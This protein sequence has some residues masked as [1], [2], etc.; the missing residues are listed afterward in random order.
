MK[1]LPNTHCKIW[2][3]KPL[4]LTFAYILYFYDFLCGRHV[5]LVAKKPSLHSHTT[6]CKV[7]TRYLLGLLNNKPVV[8]RL[9]RH[10]VCVK[11][12]ITINVIIAN[13]FVVILLEI[14]G[15]KLI[16]HFFLSLS[17]SFCCM[18]LIKL[19]FKLVMKVVIVILNINGNVK[20]YGEACQVHL[21]LASKQREAAL[22]PW[23][24]I[25]T[26][27]LWVG[28]ASCNHCLVITMALLVSVLYIGWTNTLIRH[29]DYFLCVIFWFYSSLYQYIGYL[30]LFGWEN[31]TP[32]HKF[33]Y[34]ISLC[35]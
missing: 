10:H 28:M 1:C 32:V 13:R 29:A 12:I 31:I 6:L 7:Y 35:I 11:Q 19:Y 15:R 3:D 9:Y 16:V 21:D 26:L 4:L 8:P 25:N 23:G 20:C 14:V 30:L 33:F 18:V 24:S 5:I 34:L 2:L 27:T 22:V 17:S